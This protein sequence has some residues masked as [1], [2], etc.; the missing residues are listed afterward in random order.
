MTPQGA[1]SH[2]V[3]LVWSRHSGPEEPPFLVQGPRPDEWAGAL[4]EEF[5]PHRPPSCAHLQPPRSQPSTQMPHEDGGPC[6]SPPPAPCSPRP[7]GHTQPPLHGRTHRP[8]CGPPA[9]GRGWNWGL[10]SR[11][12][13]EPDF[14]QVLRGAL[15]G[16]RGAPG[17]PWRPGPLV[18]A[19]TPAE[20]CRPGSP[21]HRQKRPCRATG[22]CPP[23]PRPRP[24]LCPS[25]SMVRRGIWNEHSER[26]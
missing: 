23:R 22:L 24:S 13:P 8:S 5:A 9:F 3:F 14:W 11:T 15:Q 26:G 7:R 17:S 18:P 20:R 19:E 21:G 6:Q 4:R 25:S 12:R 16:L 10:T 2:W 1:R